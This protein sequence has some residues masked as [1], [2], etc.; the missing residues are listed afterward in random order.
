MWLCLFCIRMLPANFLL[1]MT[2]VELNVS[3]DMFEAS[4]LNIHWK[5]TALTDYMTL[6]IGC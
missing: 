5:N 2:V 6:V 1:L 4:S 3:C